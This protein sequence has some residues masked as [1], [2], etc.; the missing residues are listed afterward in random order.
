MVNN[1]GMVRHSSTSDSPDIAPPIGVA[2]AHEVVVSGN[3]WEAVSSPVRAELVGLLEAL[4]PSTAAELA[5]AMGRRQDGLYHHLRKLESE[6]VAEIAGHRHAIRRDEAVY[7]LTGQ[8]LRLSTEPGESDAMFG[9]ARQLTTAALKRLRDLVAKGRGRFGGPESNANFRVETGWITD[10][11]RRQVVEHLR[12]IRAVFEN[13]R[14]RPRTGSP[15]TAVTV[16][17]ALDR[18][19]PN[20]SAPPETTASTPQG[21]P[22]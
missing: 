19:T 16:L 15:F 2:E 8:H 21:D 7:R 11:E 5:E 14:G 4:G 20:P 3:R 9:A 13:A 1:S 17:A 12:A 10:D 18:D 6:G 22:A